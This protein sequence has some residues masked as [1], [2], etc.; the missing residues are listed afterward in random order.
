[1]D[2]NDAADGRF[3]R[4]RAADGHGAERGRVHERGQERFALS[5]AMGL[6]MPAAARASRR[7]LYVVVAMSHMASQRAGMSKVPAGTVRAKREGVKNQ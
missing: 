2:P 1:V 4:C 5:F 6:P 3:P 7:S